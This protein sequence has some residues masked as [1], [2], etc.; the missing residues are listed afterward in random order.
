[1]RSCGKNEYSAPVYATEA[2]G[3]DFKVL[4]TIPEGSSECPA[5]L[6]RTLLSSLLCEHKTFKASEDRRF[7]GAQDWQGCKSRSPG[8]GF[9]H[10]LGSFTI[11]IC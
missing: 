2:P 4:S 11:S 8:V 7:L 9:S 6:Q 10:R 1:V 5:Q 3:L